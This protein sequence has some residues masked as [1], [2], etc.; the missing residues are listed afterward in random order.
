[1][2][3][4]NLCSLTL[5]MLSWPPSSSWVSPPLTRCTLVF[6]PDIFSLLSHDWKSSFLT[7]HFPF[8]KLSLYCQ[9]K[10]GENES[11]RK[12]FKKQFHL[13]WENCNF[14]YIGHQH[15]P[16]IVK[17]DLLWSRQKHLSFWSC[18][19]WVPASCSLT[20][21]GKTVID[22][23]YQRILLFVKILHHLSTVDTYRERVQS[24]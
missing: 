20:Q 17:R 8:W 11:K 2:S 10:F 19:L 4:G 1:M 16:S 14:C 23:W 22:G 13:Q 5:L 18:I 6:F 15:H 3:L 9:N 7:F 21:W 24:G 12:Y